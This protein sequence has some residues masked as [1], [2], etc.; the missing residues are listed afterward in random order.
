MAA[1][2]GERPGVPSQLDDLT[3][4]WLAGALAAAG[5][6]DLEVRAVSLTR[7]AVGEGFMGTLARVAPEYAGDPPGA[8]GSLVAKLPTSDPGGVALAM[9]LRLWERESRFYA[10]VA[11]HLP[12]RT[13]RCFYSGSDTEAGAFAL[14]LEDLGDLSLGDQ[15]AGLT[16]RQARLAVDWLARFHAAWWGR[17]DL[18]RLSWMPRVASDPMYEGLQPMLEAVWPGFVERYGA[19]APDDAL[20][21][22]EQLVPAFHELLAARDLPDTVIHADYRPDNLFFDDDEVAVIDWQATAVAQ[23]L[24]DLAYLLG[25]GMAVDDRRADER[26]LV[27]RYRR[28]LA[29][30]GVEGLPGPGD[31]FGLYRK[32][33]LTAT[34]VVAMLVGQLDL[35]VNERGT[36]LARNNVERMFRAASDLR[37][38]DFLEG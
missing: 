27:E 36:D 20:A 7:L 30:A 24:Y 35:E 29:A 34:G 4:D 2:A 19:L 6:G 9:L 31:V 13:P 16:P 5:L 28:G 3:A 38:G 21:W 10:E 12:V 32:N 25:T 37:V 11:P 8:P 1:D 22:A 33:V 18:A 14:L 17:E 23:G 15:V 26:E